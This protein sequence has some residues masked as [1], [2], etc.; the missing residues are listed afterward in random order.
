MSRHRDRSGTTR[1]WPGRR[2]VGR[3][4][5]TRGRPGTRVDRWR[6]SWRLA[7]RLARREVARHRGRTV[8]I[9]ALVGMPVVV[10]TALAVW[11]TSTDISRAEQAARVVGTAAARLEPTPNEDGI[12]QVADA[13]W[14][15]W[16]GETLPDPVVAEGFSPDDPWSV[17]RVEASTGERVAEVGTATAQPPDLLPGQG[18]D[19]S[20]PWF[21]VALDADQVEDAAPEQVRGADGQAGGGQSLAGI[22]SLT[23]GRWP[24]A[25]DEVLITPSGAARG[26]ATSNQ[27]SVSYAGDP[28]PTTLTVVGTGTAVHDGWR[29]ADLVVGTAG[30]P[31]STRW[32]YLVLTGEPVNL[33]RAHDWARQGLDVTSALVSADPPPGPAGYGRS[34]ESRL[35]TLLLAAAVVV[36]T[37]LLAGPAFAVSAVRQRHS[38][39]LAATQGAGAADM[40]RA[41][42]AYGLVLAVLAAVGGAVLGGAA[43]A[44]WVLW[45]VR[46]PLPQVVLLDLPWSWVAALAGIA[47]LAGGVAAW[48]PAR[49]LTRLDTMTVLRGQVASRRVGRGWP[50]VGAVLAGAGALLLVWAAVGT[51]SA[52]DVAGADR[53]VVLILA[54]AGLMGLGLLLLLPALLAL[55]ARLTRGAP[56]ALRLATRDSLRQRSRAVPA[57]AAIVAATAVMAGMATVQMSTVANQERH[58]EPRLPTGTA[59]VWVQGATE[60]RRAAVTAV[61]KD[62]VPGAVV[63]PV[64]NVAAGPGW[65]VHGEFIEEA[66]LRAVIPP[67]CG[68]TYTLQWEEGGEEC[69]LDLDATHLVLPLELLERTGQ[70]DDQAREA[71]GS[72]SLL[73]T[74]GY[75]WTPPDGLS[76]LSVLTG[77]ARA[78]ETG[79]R[80]VLGRAEVAEVPVLALEPEQMSALAVP[81]AAPATMMTPETA[82]AL[83]WLGEQSYLIVAHPD[84]DLTAADERALTA[85]FEGAVGDGLGTRVEQGFV[86]GAGSARFMV[87]L[88]GAF[89]LLALCAV[90]IS[91]ALTVTEGQRDSATLAAVG[92]TRRTRRMLAAAHS[93]VLAGLGCGVGLGLGVAVGA[94]AGWVSSRA[95][96]Y[97]TGGYMVG[98]GTPLP[99]LVAVPWVPLLLVLVLLPVVAAAIGW[100][101]VRRAP[102]LV[103]RTV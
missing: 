93:W 19:G 40:R 7:L 42:T 101:S 23:S 68:T 46:Q 103:R 30:A 67:G 81:R 88:L 37:A 94:A 34:S 32:S 70:L 5:A 61:I 77:V 73:V 65:Q 89:S 90:V 78:D 49:G 8:L 1:R 24:V 63:Y 16:Q 60:E 83:G 29:D 44:A 51:G 26:L 27:V 18:V 97:G 28:A 66:P 31:E 2:G 99:G 45:R 75:Q 17:E 6:G 33:E 59:E 102:A 14:Y 96:R 55:A 11:F 84:R 95:D 53:S 76:T 57:M 85:G 50:T 22:A 91:T 39:A 47:V 48:W 52:G 25:A 82:Q 92:G 56:V 100:V 15:G 9:L 74:G 69:W 10:L 72:G 12:G 3:V 79:E 38:L 87:V 71:L 21:V 20:G 54:A 4:G 35:L 80:S 98:D 58:Y 13:E 64:E 41:V 36:E 62:T 86:Q 43:G